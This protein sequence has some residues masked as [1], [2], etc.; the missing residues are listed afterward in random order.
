MHVSLGFWKTLYQGMFGSLLHR[1][2]IRSRTGSMRCNSKHWNQ[3]TPLACSATNL[4]SRAFSTKHP[5]ILRSLKSI[6]I[7]YIATLWQSV[8]MLG[9]VNA[10]SAC[11]IKDRNTF[12]N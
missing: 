5:Q 8:G 9:V 11:G 1:G 3:E 6:V 7:S 2:F 4:R 10:I 12:P